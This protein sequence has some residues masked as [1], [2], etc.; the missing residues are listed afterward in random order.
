MSVR[1]VPAPKRRASAKSAARPEFRFRA[2]IT[3]G[4]T[5]AIGPGKIALLEAIDRTGSITAAAQSLDMSY[6]RAWMLLDEVNRSMRELA[7]DTAKGGEHGGGSTLTSTGRQL[8]EVY[9]RIETRAE[10]ACVR[11]IKVLV[12]LLARH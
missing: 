8:I 4:E 10:T 6:R 7:V 2:R 9:R 3:W 12:G 11:D 1:K 5:I